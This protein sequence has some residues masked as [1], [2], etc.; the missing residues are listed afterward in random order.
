MYWSKEAM[1]RGK[2]AM[3][4]SKEAVYRCKEAMYWVR[5]KLFRGND[6][7]PRSFGLPDL[8]S[9]RDAR[10]SSSARLRSEG[11]RYGPFID[12]T[13]PTASAALTPAAVTYSGDRLLP[14]Y[15]GT[16][17][18]APANRDLATPT[19]IVRSPKAV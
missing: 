16:A 6:P 10:A 9:P 14:R 15:T 8:Y 11:T 2:E 18:V 17:S 19:T 5:E 1:Y 12:A 4:R 3:Y 7:L 13:Q